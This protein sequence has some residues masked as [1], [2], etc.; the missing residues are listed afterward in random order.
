VSGRA[1]PVTRDGQDPHAR[2]PAGASIGRSAALIAAL[3]IAARLLGLVR[4]LVFAK[5]VGATCLGTA[6]TTANLVPNIVYDVVLGG[7]LTSIMVPVLARPAASAGRDPAAAREV[8]QTSSALLTW[9]VVILVPV[10]AV[11]ALASGPLARL[12]NPS[13]AT[14]PRGDCTVQQHAVVTVTGHMLAVFAPQILFYG[15]A[16]VLYGI[17]QAHRRFAAPAIAPLVSSLI[18]IAAYLVFDPFGASDVAHLSRLPLAAELILAVGTTA[19]VG[20]LVVVALVPAWRLHIAVRPTLRF[21]A[22]IGR[23]AG[24]LAI[25]GI[26]ALITQDVASL[27]VVLL[28]NGHGYRGALVLY[29]YGWQ[30]FEACYAVLA[31][32]VSVS[33]FPVLAVNEGTE[34]DET[35]AS[36]TR[37]VL[38]LS[39]LGTA[40]IVAISVPAAHVLASYAGQVPQLAAGF[41]LFALGLAGYGLVAC[42][43]RVLLAAGRTA[44]AAIIVSGGWVLV[45]VADI[46]L[47]SEAH[48]GSVVPLLALGNTIGLTAS[49]LALFVA[50]GRVRGSAALRGTPRAA[51]CGAAAAIAG[52]GAGAGVAAALPTAGTLA[53]CFTGLLAAVCAVAAFGVV[54]WFLDNGDLRAAL[55]RARRAV[56]R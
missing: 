8:S 1:V 26:A 37:A 2:M 24:G 10:S 51:I 15:L 46:V 5:T 40:V 12:L 33:A 50:V 55:G 45:I 16:V 39:L 30:V 32:S 52:A 34:F 25:Y 18:V 53:E 14:I 29:G 56:T 17:L 47:I 49:G 28:A 11:I 48:G 31:I 38:L 27:V 7:A 42:L 4:T 44:T 43:S 21:P 3:T 13:N 20:A 22:G 35:A 54:A 19:G 41:A 23:R 36:S 6:Y 9:T